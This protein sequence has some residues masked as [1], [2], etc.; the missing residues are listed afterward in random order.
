MIT[1]EQIPAVVGQP[2]LDSYGDKI[3][4][5]VQVFVDDATGEP[6]WVSVNTGPLG[7]DESLVPLREAE[8]VGDRLQVSYAHDTVKDAPRIDLY[9]G[10]VHL[11]AGEER[12]LR[13]Y[14]GI[15]GD[16]A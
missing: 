2:V 12:L 5:A 4:T 6:R 9:V 8:M 16:A 13:K 10:G 15:Q 11:T 1:R 14:Y 7:V 3:G